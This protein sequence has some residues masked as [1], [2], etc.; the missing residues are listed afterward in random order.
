M[1][2]RWLILSAGLALAS[3]AAVWAHD[4]NPLVSSYID[5]APAI[6]GDLTDWDQIPFHEVTPENGVFDSESAVAD[7]AADQSFTFAVANDG[8]YLYVAVMIRDDTLIL[9]TNPDPAEKFARAWMDDA[10]EIFLDGDHSHSPDARDAAGQE[11]KTGG[12]FSIVA[13]GAVTSKMSGVPGKGGDP[14]YWISAGSYG[15]P[16]GAAYQA[17][18]DTT[19]VGFAVEA[20]FNLAILG[21][22]VSPGSTIG[23]TVSAH[24]DDDGEGRDTA[25]YWKGLSPHCW[26][27]EAGW[28]DV[29]LSG[30]PTE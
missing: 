29:V 17:P 2:K 12:E 23:M 26:K 4:P 15:P 13:N 24:D 14:A 25:L 1:N 18:W 28:G 11:Y 9:D 27:N 16:P 8:Q 20:R 3:C 21:A 6:D 22:N 10:V 19:G 7:N 5:K 30:P